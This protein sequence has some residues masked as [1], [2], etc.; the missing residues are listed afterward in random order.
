MTFRVFISSVQDEFAEER[1]R[2]KEWLTTDLFVSRFVESVF[3]FEETPAR[4]RNPVDTYLEEV[5]ASDI[6]IGLVGERYYGVKSAQSGVS[7]TEKE[8]DAAG[9]AG[10]ERFVYLKACDR[11]G[12]KARQFVRKVN[13][14]VTRT[15]FATFEDLRTAVYSSLVE[16]L[17]ARKLIEVGDFDKSVCREMTW[18]D[19]DRERVKWY[20]GEMARR[21]P[22]AALPVTTSAEELFTRLGLVKDGC[23]TWAAALCFSK[24]PQTWSYRTTLKCS[25]SEGTEFG[26]PLLDTDKFEG[27]LFALLKD[28]TDYVMSRISQSRGLRTEGMVAPT[29]DE[30]PREAVEEA[31]INALVH[32]NWRLTSSV[33]VR[34]F[35]DRVEV[36]T[37]GTLPSQI[38]IPELYDIHT[39]YP[40]NELLLKVFDFAGIIESLGTGIQRMIAACRKASLPDPVWEQKG[41]AFIVTLWKDGWTRARLLQAGVTERQMLAIPYLKEKRSITA[42]AYMTLTGVARNTATNDLNKLVNGG[43]LEKSG[44]GKGTFYR[45]RL[46]T[47]Y[48]HYA[49]DEPIGFH[50]NTRKKPAKCGKKSH[51]SL[52]AKGKLVDGEVKNE[53]LNEAINEVIKEAIKSTPGIKK[54]RLVTAVGKSKA[55]VERALAALIA[56]GKVEHRGSKKTG[57]YHLVGEAR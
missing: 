43:V 57:G 53:G 11:R 47:F 30:L 42:E 34:L 40:V 9:Q 2:L 54:P 17:D 13:A 49:H 12:P 32:R 21:K 55:T 24:C 35:S 16:F 56:A 7:A 1:R 39:S 18:K 8:F 14:E 33:D 36:W 28:G 19:V 37:P 41:S 6:Y 52:I 50:A 20:L 51:K 46:C 38:T 4:G 29:K 22:R 31:I 26:R 48:A 15:V 45:L 23:F 25:W 44:I 10:C 27:N 5:R 3:L